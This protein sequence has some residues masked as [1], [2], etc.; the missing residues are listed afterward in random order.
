[1]LNSR[2]RIGVSLVTERAF[3]LNLEI[4]EGWFPRI[5]RTSDKENVAVEGIPNFCSGETCGSKDDDRIM[6]GWW[7]AVPMSSK[8]LKPKR[9]FNIGHASMMSNFALS[10]AHS[11]APSRFFS[12]L[13]EHDAKSAL[14]F[15]LGK[16]I[17][18]FSKLSPLL[19]GSVACRRPSSRGA[20]EVSW[21]SGNNMDAPSCI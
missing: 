2:Q 8:P 5:C 6:G 21:Q 9:F 13:H 18:D 7:I 20:R 19:M 17:R 14:F 11:S 3:C 12:T 15:G 4:S 10:W 1:M 16:F